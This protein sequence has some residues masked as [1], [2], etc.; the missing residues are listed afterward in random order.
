MKK[1]ILRLSSTQVKVSPKYQVVIP[2][3]VRQQLNIVVGATL[4][5]FPYNG[6]IE[7]VPV[8]NIRNLKGMFRGIDTTIQREQDRI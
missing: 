5:I 3:L 8:E 4:E 2:K 6:R 7:I 1:S